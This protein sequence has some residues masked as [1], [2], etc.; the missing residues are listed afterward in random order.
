M[1]TLFK[2]Y[3]YPSETDIKEVWDNSLIVFDTCALLNLY[4]YTEK[5]RDDFV[6]LLE[7]NKERLWIPYQVAMEFLQN[8]NEVIKSQEKAYDEIN[9]SL[10]DTFKKVESTFNNYK[11]HVVLDIEVFKT[12]IKNFID[13]IKKEL[14]KT[15]SKH[16]KYDKEDILLEKI[17]S[18]LE[19]RIGNDFSEDDLNKL[20]K[21]GENRYKLQIPPGYKDAKNKNNQGNRHLYGD[22]I[23]W[24]QIIKKA[25]DEKCNIIFVTDDQKEDWWLIEN[26]KTI[27]PRLELYKEF[28]EETKQRILIYKADSFLKNSNTYLKGGS[29]KIEKETIEEVQDIILKSFILNDVLKDNMSSY[30]IDLP[31]HKNFTIYNKNMPESLLIDSGDNQYSLYSKIIPDYLTVSPTSDI[32]G[33]HSKITPEHLTIPPTSDLLGIHSKITPEHLTVLPT[34]DLLGIHSKIT[35]EHLTVPPTSDILGIHGK[36]THEHLTVSPTSE[37]LGIHSRITPESLLNFTKENKD[38]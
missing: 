37:I 3:F 9:R 24:K 15:H 31:T 2:E 26:G 17:S 21:I 28:F 1:K 13:N 12:K 30:Q 4:R 16:P 14:D 35:P 23:V 10:E 6:N 25:L 27:S 34:S 18:V 19:N 20:Y 32:L 5:T 36:I 11:K 33:I 22:L 8:K 7:S 38:S 29:D